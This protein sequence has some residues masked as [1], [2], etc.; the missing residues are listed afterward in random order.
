[1]FLEKS[2]KQKLFLTDAQDIRMILDLLNLPV[3]LMRMSQLN[4]CTRAKLMA[5]RLWS[6]SRNQSQCALLFVGSLD[7]YGINDG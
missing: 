5:S 2:K 1:V 7:L 6:S 3:V 4:A